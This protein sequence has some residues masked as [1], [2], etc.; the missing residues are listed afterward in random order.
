M[1]SRFLPWQHA[2]ACALLLLASA[3]ACELAGRESGVCMAAADVQAAA[4]Y[5][6][7]LLPFSACVQKDRDS[8]NS[9]TLSARKDAWLSAAVGAFIAQR[10][11]IENGALA[12]N[13]PSL[14]S[15]VP[16]GARATPRFTAA[17]ASAADC[18]AAFRSYACWLAFPRCDASRHSLPMC[19]SVCENYFKV[20]GVRRWSSRLG[21]Y[22]CVT[23]RHA[24]ARAVCWSSRLGSVVA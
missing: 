23:A 8:R 20:S 22:V 9:T 4:P 10:T 19:R 12:P 1:P 5:C 17:G 24:S 18:A 13:D 7:S 15:F 11:A 16:A 2:T 14:S 6:A 3:R 21:V